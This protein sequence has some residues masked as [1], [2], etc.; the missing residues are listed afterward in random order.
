[1]QFPTID[2]NSCFVRYDT[3]G[4]VTG[5]HVP[6]LEQGSLLLSSPRMPSRLMFRHRLRNLGPRSIHGDVSTATIHSVHPFGNMD[7]LILPCGKS[8]HDRIG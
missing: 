4:F 2:H 5:S 8:T 3:P 6:S 1:M 7:K